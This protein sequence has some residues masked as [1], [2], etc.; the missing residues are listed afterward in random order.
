M[1]HGYVRDLL[2]Q[3]D[4]QA[5]VRAVDRMP[6]P[7]LAAR[8]GSVGLP[9]LAVDRI[10]LPGLADIVA[11]A[12]AITMSRSIS[13]SGCLAMNSSATCMA[14]RATPRRWS[15][16]LPRLAL[17]RARIAFGRRNLADPLVS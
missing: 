13:S 1:R 7:R 16:W 12:P 3:P 11:G 10:E 4:R 5:D 9:A 14:M 17:V 2:G 6:E 8:D 15:V